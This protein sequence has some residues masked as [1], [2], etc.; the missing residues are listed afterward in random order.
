MTVRL[1]AV[2]EYGLEIY[3][4]EL[5]RD[6]DTYRHVCQ[7]LIVHTD[8]ADL[9]AVYGEVYDRLDIADDMQANPVQV[10]A[11]YPGQHRSLSHRKR[12]WSPPREKLADK[13]HDSEDGAHL[14]HVLKDNTFTAGSSPGVQSV[15]LAL[16]YFHHSYRAYL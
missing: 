12:T 14:E 13:D 9:G 6:G 5:L 1:P 7:Y 8:R 4:C 16:T 2:G 11:T 10:S 15:R 3:A